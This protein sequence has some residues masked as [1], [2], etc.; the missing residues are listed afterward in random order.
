MPLFLNWT[1]VGLLTSVTSQQNNLSNLKITHMLMFPVH[2]R[3][4]CTDKQPVEVQGD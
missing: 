1:L 3:Y 2:N 4:I